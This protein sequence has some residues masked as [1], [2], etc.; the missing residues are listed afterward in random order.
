MRVKPAGIKYVHM[1]DIQNV[2][3]KDRM[4]L[5]SQERIRDGKHYLNDLSKF[6]HAKAHLARC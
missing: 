5:Q 4:L 1:C 6:Q 3:P 2:G